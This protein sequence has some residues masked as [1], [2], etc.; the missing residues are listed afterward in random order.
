MA[1]NNIYG[2]R[3]GGENRGSTYSNTLYNTTINNSQ[4]FNNTYGILLQGDVTNTM[5]HNSNIYNNTYG[6]QTVASPS[7]S[8]LV[9]SIHMT[10]SNIYNNNVGIDLTNTSTTMRYYGTGAITGNTT[11]SIGSYAQ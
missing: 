1:Y 10:S 6:I 2:I 4:L 11:N 9:G 3:L 7:S 8:D 5:I